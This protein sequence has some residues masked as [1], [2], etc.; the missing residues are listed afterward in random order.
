MNS[1]GL[2]AERAAADYLKKH[3]LKLLDYNYY[4]KFGEIDL[5]FKDKRNIIFV[6]VKARQAKRGIAPKEYVDIH[7]QRKIILAAQS[8]LSSHPSKLQPRF[9]VVEVYFEND[10]IKSIEHLENAFNLDYNM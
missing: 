8:Y 3:R 2:L 4:T 6:E 10:T 9:D 7:K 5:I 1:N